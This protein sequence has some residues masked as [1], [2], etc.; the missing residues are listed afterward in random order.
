MGARTVVLSF[1]ISLLFGD[2]SLC[3][4]GPHQLSPLQDS[5]QVVYE[6]LG[7]AVAID[8]LGLGFLEPVSAPDERTQISHVPGI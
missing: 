4:P 7:I 3:T 8:S 2:I 1:R 5:N 6:V